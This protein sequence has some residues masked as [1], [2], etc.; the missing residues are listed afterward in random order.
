MDLHRPIFQTTYDLIVNCIESASDAVCKLIL[1]RS[2]EEKKEKTMEANSWEDLE[3]PTKGLTVS[4]DVTW[5][6]RGF[7]YLQGVSNVTANHQ[8][9]A[10][11]M[12]VDTIR[13]IFERSVPSYGVK[14]L[15]YIGDGD[16]RTYKG[17]VDASP[18][19]S[20]VEISKNECVE[21]VQKRMGTWLHA[22]KKQIKGLGRRGKLTGKSLPASSKLDLV[23]NYAC[24]GNFIM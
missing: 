24:I 23:I 6:K 22:C 11:K 15:N 17:V 10:G 5:R 18:Y 2:V 20:S 21:H 7:N 1:R 4:G 19:G 8:G 9:S 3:G 13:E 14:Y 12:E 16:S